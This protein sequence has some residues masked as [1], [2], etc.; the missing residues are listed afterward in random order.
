MAFGQETVR[1][2]REED[3]FG[4]SEELV[5]RERESCTSVLCQWL[6]MLVYAPISPQV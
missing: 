1:K 4:Q 3:E 2:E 6:R 5:A